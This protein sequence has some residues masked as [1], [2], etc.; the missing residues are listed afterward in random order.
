MTHIVAVQGVLPAHRYHQREI[1]DALAAMCRP[2]ADG[3]AWDRGTL[4]R[5]HA[6]A[7]VRTRHLV[8]PLERYALL[9]G[10]GQANDLFIEEGLRLG[11]EALRAALDQAG[12]AP[13]QVDLVFATSVTGIAA[14]S[15]EA[16]LAGRLGLRPDVKRVPVFGLGCV[17]GAAG[18]ARV[19][20]YLQ[21]HPDQV[22]VLLSV[23]LCSLTLQRGDTSVRNMVVGAL[24]G[25]GAAA[26]VAVGRDHPRL[27]E[28]AGPRVVATRSRLYPGTERALGWDIG[29]RGFAIVLGAELP[30][31]VRLHLGEEVH[32]FLA[33][34]DLKPDDIT[35]WVCHP[36]GPKVLEA[37]QETLGLGPASLELTWRSLAHVGNLSSASVLHV[38][39]DTL[40]LRPPPRD[41]P[42][43][44]LAL[45]PGFSSELVLLR[46]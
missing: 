30:D 14:P 35:G 33:A 36:G 19:H 46:W 12:L 38:L 24:F 9:D 15:L 43:L 8:L 40:D 22:A 29:D 26:L 41:T 45:G 44:L 2:G 7:C 1:A 37:L 5:L 13:D 28:C 17:A 21:G 34:H 16:R 31:L 4:D 11:E 3:T 32:S 23:E 6:T 20:D 27:R 18:L 39:R 10:F 25:D 42:G